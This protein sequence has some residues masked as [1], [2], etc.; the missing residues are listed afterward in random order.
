MN[1]LVNGQYNKDICFNNTE[2][3][4]DMASDLSDK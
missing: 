4:L 3:F 1:N 2:Y